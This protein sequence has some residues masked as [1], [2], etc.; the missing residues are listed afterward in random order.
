MARTSVPA[1]IWIP[2][3]I[4]RVTVISACALVA[5]ITS[6]APAAR[7]GASSAAGATGWRVIR[8][9]AAK[10]TQ[11]S[12]GIAAFKD[13]SVWLGGQTP[14]QTPFLYHRTSSGKWSRTSLPGSTGTFVDGLS[15]SSTSNVWAVLANE[16]D[17]AHLTSH[18]WV[19]KSFTQ[20]TS[21][22]LIAAVLTFSPKST[23][24]FY[25]AISDP[26]GNNTGYAVHFD[27]SSWHKSKLPA[28]VDA[29]SLIGV[30]SASSASNIWALT[31]VGSHYASLHYDGHSWKIVSLPQNVAPPGV[32]VF[33]RQILVQS[34]TSAWIA[35][36][37]AGAKKVGPIV[38]LHWDGKRWRRISAHLPDGALAGPIAADGQGGLWLTANT[39]T[40]AFAAE[41]MHFSKG[42]W[43]IVKNPASPVPGQP[44]TLSL[45]VHV[46]G[47]AS[48]MLAE[49]IVGLAGF[50]TTDGAVVVKFGR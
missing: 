17:V 12:G 14:A 37:A 27:G 50:G 33:P 38:L 2:A 25:T 8:T 44:I 31:F 49:G 29:N 32:T 30:V 45:L 39:A 15:A 19:L 13:G 11:L 10:G 9:L 3:P 41:L 6:A 18:G 28:P 26:P 20:G 7:A 21:E 43:T 46:P 40:K 22:V 34:K 48:S 35:A 4:R 36:F 23:W 16:P 5:L 47:T 24:V 42:K 1:L